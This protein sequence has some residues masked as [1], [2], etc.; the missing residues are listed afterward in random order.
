MNRASIRRGPEGPEGRNRLF[1]RGFTLLEMC[2][3][4]LIIALLF[5]VSMPA[6][7]AAFVEQAVRKDSHELALMVKTAMIQ[8]AEQ[9]RP[10]VI[11]LSGTTMAL[12]PLGS[13]AATPSDGDDDSDAGGESDTGAN[14]LATP[15]VDQNW[16]LQ[17][18]TPVDIEL[19]TVLDPPNQLQAPDPQKVNAWM[20]MPDNTEWVF[21][22]G[23]LCPATQVRLARGDA[24]I[25]LNFNALTGN[26]ED[27]TSYIP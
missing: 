24:W 19:T 5:G 18:I 27:E 10:Y 13:T 7:Q 17:K 1:L 12:H 16:V 23:E 11:D 26:V 8:T 20:A 22:P 9:N 6:I 21:Q 4:L 15:S 3:V 14:A 2:M 25:Q